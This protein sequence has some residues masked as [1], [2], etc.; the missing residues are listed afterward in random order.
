VPQPEI[1]IAT[2]LHAWY[3]AIALAALA[4]GGAWIAAAQAGAQIETRFTDFN[5][6]R[7]EAFG[8][9]T[10]APGT[11]RVILLGSSALK[12]ATRDEGEFSA[13]IASAAGQPVAALRITSN[14]GTFYDFQPLA[15]DIL[16]LRPDLVV[17]DTEFLA[18][19][20]PQ[21]RRFLLLIRD[22]RRSLGLDVPDDDSGDR[23]TDIQFGHPCWRRKLQR[24]HEQLLEV[25]TDWAEIRPEGPGPR[26]AR[27]FAEQLLDQGA[28]V[29]FLAIPRRPDYETEARGRREIANGAPT[30]HALAVRSLHWQPEPIPTG[31]YCDLTHVTPAGRDRYSTWLETMIAGRFAR[32]GS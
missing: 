24:N 19:D 17:M 22:A 29:A 18:G 27:Q 15:E 6:A 30:A 11:R 21:S 32:P 23:E 4:W 8:T 5:R 13:R 9:D 7:I 26:G 1:R 2:P 12:Y 14:W 20:R 28:E 3:L 10:E 16:H 31:F 25:R